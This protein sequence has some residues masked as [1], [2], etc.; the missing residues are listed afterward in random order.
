M[1]RQYSH[2]SDSHHSYDVG[3]C[4]STASV[5][6]H[7]GLENE[8]PQDLHTARWLFPLYLILMGLFVLQIAWAGPGIT[9]GY[10][11]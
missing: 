8:R 9:Y 11:G 7:G 5:S 4:L 1:N 3:D 10:A 2:L 6:H